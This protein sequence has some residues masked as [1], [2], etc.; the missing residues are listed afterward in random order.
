MLWN[1]KYT[2]IPARQS[3]SLKPTPPFLTSSQRWFSSWCIS[4]PVWEHPPAV[5]PPSRLCAPLSGEN[6][7]PDESPSSSLSDGGKTK[8]SKSVSL[9]RLEADTRLPAACWLSRLAAFNISLNLVWHGFSQSTDANVKECFRGRLFLHFLSILHSNSSTGAWCWWFWLVEFL[10]G[11]HANVLILWLLTP[12]KLMCIL[13]KKTWLVVC[14]PLGGAAEETVACCRCSDQL[15]E[16]LCQ[17][18]FRS[19]SNWLNFPR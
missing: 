12:S 18:Q 8:Q 5:A 7:E 9:P 14:F 4:A 1:D 16:F 6:P 17:R 19:K 10:V 11:A 13:D 2:S 15:L 3:T